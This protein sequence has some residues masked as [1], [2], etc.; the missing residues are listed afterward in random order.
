MEKEFFD[1]R[2]SDS[3]SSGTRKLPI[4]VSPT[5]LCEH[6]KIQPILYQESP[7][8]NKQIKIST[9]LVPIDYMKYLL[10]I[11]VDMYEHLYNSI[12]QRK[13]R[14]LH[15]QWTDLYFKIQ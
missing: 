9:I 15:L 14:V 4:F 8:T 6:S 3:I 5:F 7:Y 10:E 13:N 2:S 11:E 1:T 12:L